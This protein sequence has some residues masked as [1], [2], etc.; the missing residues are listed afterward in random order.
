MRVK[1]IPPVNENK[2]RTQE[3]SITIAHH[4]IRSFR[5]HR[6]ELL[7]FLEDTQPDIMTLNEI[8]TPASYKFYIPGY[9][10]YTGGRQNERGGGVVSKLDYNGGGKGGRH[11]RSGQRRIGKELA[12]FQR[13][14]DM[15]DLGKE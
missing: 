11:V 15:Q 13:E 10:V 6:A 8:R 1:I 3:H 4:N 12:Q 2:S 7:A 14:E 9:Q 5:S